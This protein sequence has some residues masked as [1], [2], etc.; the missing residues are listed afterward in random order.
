M[1]SLQLSFIHDIYN[2]IFSF[3]TGL[4]HVLHL[5][6]VGWADKTSGQHH[7]TSV[8][9]EGTNLKSEKFIIYVKKAAAFIHGL[10]FNAG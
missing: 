8:H 7:V 9:H 6:T 5:H 1:G 10:R 4:L 2:K 3:L